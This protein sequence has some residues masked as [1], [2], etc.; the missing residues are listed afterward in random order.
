MRTL[1][2][3]PD[4]DLDEP[5][6]ED[7]RPQIILGR[8]LADGEAVAIRNS[9]PKDY[10]VGDVIVKAPGWETDWLSPEE[11]EASIIETRARVLTLEEWQ[12]EQA[13]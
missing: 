13:A 10:G 3:F 5:P 2:L 7:G 4:M 8:P 9:D 12:A 1:F 11:I 6:R